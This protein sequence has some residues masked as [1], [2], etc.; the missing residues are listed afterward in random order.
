MRIPFDDIFDF[1]VGLI[2]HSFHSDG[3]VRCEM[4]ADQEDIKPAEL[5]HAWPDASTRSTDPSEFPPDWL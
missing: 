4:I 3:I 2:E 1:G 5:D